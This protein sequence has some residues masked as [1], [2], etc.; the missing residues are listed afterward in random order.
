VVEYDQGNEDGYKKRGEITSYTEVDETQTQWNSGWYAVKENVTIEGGVVVKGTVNLILCD[1]VVLNVNSGIE[2]S[3]G[4]TLRI[5]GQCKGDGTLNAT[6]NA[7][8]TCK[9][10]IGGAGTNGNCGVIEIYGGN[11]NATGG[12]YS[13]GIGGA[14]IDPD[15]KTGG[16]GGT[17][18][19]YG[20][21][22]KAQGGE[23]APGI[24]GSLNSD[25]GRINLDGGSIEATGGEY[26]AGIGGGYYGSSGNILASGSFITSRGGIFGAGIG[27]GYKGEMTSFKMTEGHV[28]ACGGGLEETDLWSEEV[29]EPIEIDGAK[30]NGGAG[31]GSGYGADS[32]KIIITGGEVYAYGG[33]FSAGIGS[34][35]D[36]DSKTIEISDAYAQIYGGTGAADLGSGY[37]LSKDTSGGN[38]TIFEGNVQAGDDRNTTAGIGDGLHQSGNY[39][40]NSN[41]TL[42]WD[43]YKTG[44]IKFCRLNCNTQI[45]SV[46]CFTADDGRFLRVGIDQFDF[47]EMY[48]HWLEPYAESYAR[49][50]IA[51]GVLTGV[52]EF[53]P[54]SC[55]GDYNPGLIFDGKALE[56]D[57]D[58]KVILKKDGVAVESISG[59]GTYTA[60]FYGMGPYVGSKS[61]TFDVIEN[62]KSLNL[63]DVYFHGLTPDTTYIVDWSRNFSFPIGI[64]GESGTVRIYVQKDEW[65]Y[66]DGGIAVPEGT[67]LILDG[68]GSVDALG[69]FDEVREICRAGIG[70]NYNSTCGTIIINNCTVT[71]KGAYGEFSNSDYRWKV[72]SAGI[73]GGAN[74]SNGKVIIN[75][76]NIT[77]YGGGYDEGKT[78]LGAAGIGGGAGNIPSDYGTIKAD[79]GEISIYGGT[80]TAY[81][82]YGSAGIGGGMNGN[83]TGIIIEGGEVCAEGGQS[84]AGIGGGIGGSAA[85]NIHGGIVIAQGGKNGAG[86]GGG[87]C[88]KTGRFSIS[89]GIIKATGA[90]GGAG[91]GGGGASPENYAYEP[92]GVGTSYICG[93]DITAKSDWTGYGIGPGTYYNANGVLENIGS[94]DDTITI[95]QNPHTHFK[96]KP[97]SFKGNPIFVKQFVI[98]D[99][100]GPEVATA[101]NMDG[102]TVLPTYN[103]TVKQPEEGG[104]LKV[105]NE[106]AYPG[107]KVKVIPSLEEDWELSF[108]SGIYA[109]EFLYTD[110][111]NEFEM[112]E[113]DVEVSM[114]L[115]HDLTLSEDD[116]YVPDLDLST[117]GDERKPEMRVTY[118]GQLL[119]PEWDYYVYFYKVDEENNCSNVVTG[120]GDY[121]AEIHATGKYQG[122]VTKTFKVTGTVPTE[123]PTEEPTQTPTLEP[124][125]TPTLVPTETPTTV[126]SEVPTEVPTG[127]STTVP[128]DVPTTAPTGAV[129]TEVPSGVPTTAPTGA[130]STEAPSDVPTTAPTKD[131]P[132]EEPSGAPTETPIEIPI[133]L[134]TIGPSGE[135]V[136]NPGS[137][138]PL[139]TPEPGDTSITTFVKRLYKLCLGR[140]ADQDGLDFWTLKLLNKEYTGAYAGAHFFLSDEFTKMKLSDEDYLEHL[141][142][143]MMG[144]PSDEGG[145]KY[146]GDLLKSGVGRQYVLQGFILSP[147]FESI[148][149][150]Y[151]IERGTYTPSEGSSKSVKLSQFVGRLYNCT[152]KRDF[153]REG[154]NFW[155]EQLYSKKHTVTTMCRFFYMSDEFKGFNTDDLE[156]MNRLYAT[157]FGRTQKDDPDG[158]AFWMDALKNDP[159]WTRESVLQYFINSPE[160]TK[161]KAQF[162]L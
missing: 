132:T 109:N 103:V 115:E 140:D 12:K 120:A 9:A 10:G 154:I 49:K 50:D 130:V 88:G 129:S 58:F 148:C 158:F 2:V 69:Q 117:C 80:V 94:Y 1:G 106:K 133:E 153:D 97:S 32:Q 14:L 63:S 113:Y 112:P 83:G 89:D 30:A 121:Y 22:I 98:E 93:G 144:R 87:A 128:S 161:I 147:E 142:N 138:T 91:I 45:N 162:G 136:I 152:M 131:A 59:A 72:A 159:H 111:N 105:S 37:G 5:Y 23:C 79:G 114:F 25:G 43:D 85:V 11:I 36:G 92:G 7:I 122:T 26:A 67:T 13:A 150:G 134:P 46:Y 29:P 66:V 55:I 108:I 48:G 34:G 118:K 24:G 82:G 42:S 146:W 119:Y 21:V 52:G 90:G 51:K 3:A 123:R 44:R 135:P 53:Y 6:G 100:L 143:V 28:V 75:G 60:E 68:P 151:G 41:L 18:S 27:G 124:T 160:F 77:A 78:D 61:K 17:I 84:G 62:L 101:T 56:K 74:G 126:P 38:I 20:G 139:A 127:V 125:E 71:A 102:K 16:N 81:G 8:N 104:T 137:P 157:F 96:L 4:N 141:Y 70:G 33:Y 64:N 116:V 15:T 107:M 31:I 110:S 149:K 57:E 86:I 95:T 145:M 99:T 54:L 39:S 73:G 19:I 40:R 76:G 47:N 35:C 65:L 155:C 156:Y